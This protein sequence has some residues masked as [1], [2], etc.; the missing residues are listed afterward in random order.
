MHLL[1]GLAV[2]NPSTDALKISSN[3]DDR[4][5]Q[6]TL[7]RCLVTPFPAPYL[8]ILPIG[9]HMSYDPLPCRGQQELMGTAR[10][11]WMDCPANTHLPFT[12]SIVWCRRSWFL[13]I[14]FGLPYQLNPGI[15]WKV[16]WCVKCS[17]S[18][19]IGWNR[20]NRSGMKWIRAGGSFMQE[21]V[22]CCRL[23][24]YFGASAVFLAKDCIL[25]SFAFNWRKCT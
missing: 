20:V 7:Y 18:I 1:V 5:V 10:C 19:W 8:L 13:R 12:L 25:Y 23:V 2:C 4:C 22:L 14:R 21:H 16:S 11:L 9:G 15:L 3:A 6:Q 24:L 17:I